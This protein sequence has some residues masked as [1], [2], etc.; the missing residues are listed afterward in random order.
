MIYGGGHSFRTTSGRFK[1]YRL[2]ES[3]ITPA[4]AQ[5]F[6]LFLTIL[7]QIYFGYGSFFTAV[8]RV[9]VDICF[10]KIMY[11][12]LL[13]YGDTIVN[14]LVRTCYL[15]IFLFLKVI[16]AAIWTGAFCPD[17]QGHFAPNLGMSAMELAR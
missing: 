13:L 14:S 17:G 12:C 11:C 15:C 16:S 4:C 8:R 1:S 9:F 2:K 10:I 7:Y 5:C 3:R 6:A